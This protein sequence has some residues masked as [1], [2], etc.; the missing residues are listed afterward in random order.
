[1][2]KAITLIFAAFT[3]MLSYVAQDCTQISE[4]NFG[5]DSAQIK[6]CR[7]NLSLY[8]EYLKQKNYRCSKILD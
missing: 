7:Q 1:M 2:K 3:M 8:S 5:S 6:N 4:P